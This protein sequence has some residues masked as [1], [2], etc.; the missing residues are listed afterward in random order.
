MKHQTWK[1]A[2]KNVQY[3]IINAILKEQIFPD[4][5]RV[6]EYQGLIE[7]QYKG[8]LLK[9]NKIRKSAMARYDFK[10]P[11]SY[12]KGEE[13]YEVDSVEQLIEILDSKFDIP[14]SERLTQ[15]LISCRDGFVLTY[16]H[17]CNRQSLID[18]TLK[19]SRM[20]ETINFFS[21]IQ[22]MTD[23]GQMN[24]LSYSESLVVEGH[25]TH[26]LSKTKL[27]L[28]EDEV[29]RYAPEFEKIIPLKVML[30]HKDDSVTT[31]MENDE[32]FILDF[33]IPEY[34]Y[35]LKAFLE[36]YQLELNDY[37]VLLVHPWQYENVIV[38]QFSEWI[39]ARQLLPTPFEIESKATLS[40][41]TMELVHKPF[42]IKLPINVQ[43]TSAVRTVSPVTTVDGPKLSYELQDMLDIYPQLQVSMEPYGIHAK[44]DPDIARHLGCIV[45]YQPV[46]ADNGTTL[47]TASLVNKNPVDNSVIV[48]SYLDWL[49]EGLTV[50][51]IEKFMKYYAKSLIEPL[52][53]YIQDY[54]I[55]LEAH[56][57]NT[58]VN[59]GPDYQMKFIVRDLG[60]SR[61]D[62]ATLQRI[63]PGI[64]ITN[65]SLIAENIEAV[66]AKFQHAVI[67]NQIAEFIH[68]FSNYEQVEEEK[69]YNIVSD[70]VYAAIDPNKA[71]AQV[72]KEVLFGKTIT[73]KSLLRMR[74]ESKVK[75]YV[76]IDLTNPIYKEV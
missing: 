39:K 15:E 27:P 49:G 31:S 64:D 25:P 11:L 29:K 2:D 53:A 30:I 37:N 36:P 73:V 72:L 47:V 13:A 24:D 8:Q 67:Q 48:D 63:K 62:L 38:K 50:T 23:S 5:M 51:S 26:P 46:L 71:H 68:H 44:T 4:G 9:V 10:G 16:E 61:I 17:F 35:K 34:R 42:H 12:L 45:R 65:T 20:P 69:L 60:G 22:H 55:A 32:Q 7:L 6:N 76:T 40:F 21:W 14:I 58:I 43:A 66:I 52:I 57:Q 56:M 1:C 59:L 33:I 3:R 28:T 54:G 19:F 75:Q 41:R 18:A 70:I 74:M